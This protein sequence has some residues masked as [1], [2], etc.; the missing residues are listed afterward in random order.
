MTSVKQSSHKF[1]TRRGVLYPCTQ[2]IFGIMNCCEMV[3]CYRAVLVKKKKKNICFNMFCL[4]NAACN[5][6]ND[7]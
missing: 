7:N 3:V 6:D 1:M 5:S 4:A 2:N